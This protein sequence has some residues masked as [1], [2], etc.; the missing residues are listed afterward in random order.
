MREEMSEKMFMDRRSKSGEK[1]HVIAAL[2][3]AVVV[4]NA[5]GNSFLRA[6]MQATGEVVSANPADYVKGLLN[7]W[8]MAG[9][10]MLAAWFFLELLLLS[11]ADLTYVLPVTSWS[12]ILTALIGVFILREEV[13]IA[14]WCGMTLIAAG[15]MIVG[16][17]KPL[18][19]GPVER[20]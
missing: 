14:H 8:S 10:V 20:L 5:V 11:L 9:I 16:Q 12:Y 19:R 15:V 4:T 6:G 7:T 17:T 18:T 2:A 13:S 1:R 3:T